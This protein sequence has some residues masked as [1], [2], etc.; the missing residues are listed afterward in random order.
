MWGN[1]LKTVI[2]KYNERKKKELIRLIKEKRKSE[3]RLEKEMKKR[4]NI[5]YTTKYLKENKKLLTQNATTIDKDEYEE[6]ISHIKNNWK[7]PTGCY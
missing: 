7:T 6:I 1:K 5:K 3:K 2:E 4:L